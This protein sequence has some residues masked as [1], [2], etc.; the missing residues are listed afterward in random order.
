MTFVCVYLIIGIIFAIANVEAAA[1]VPHPRLF[2]AIFIILF[3]P[4]IFVLGMI[5]KLTEMKK[6]G[7][8]K[9]W[10]EELKKDSYS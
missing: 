9:Y 6:L 2:V 7:W 8:K 10:E 5:D 1:I 4:I 3:W